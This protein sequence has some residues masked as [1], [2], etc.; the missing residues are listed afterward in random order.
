MVHDG[1]MANLKIGVAA[2]EH[3]ERKARPMNAENEDH[4]NCGR[5]NW[6]PAV[7]GGMG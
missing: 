7:F 1:V 6:F 5:G 3:Q 2:R 4:N